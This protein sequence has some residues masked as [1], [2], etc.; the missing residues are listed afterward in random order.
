MVDEQRRDL[1]QS[2]AEHLPYIFW[3]DM[4]NDDNGYNYER[5]AESD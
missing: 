3:D 1:E 5:H 2:A 4:W